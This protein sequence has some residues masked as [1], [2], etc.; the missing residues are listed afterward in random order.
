VPLE[1]VTLQL[2]QVTSVNLDQKTISV[3]SRLDGSIIPGIQMQPATHQQYVPVVGQQ[4]ML[5]RISDFF[6]GVLAYLGSKPFV[7]PVQSGEYLIESVGGA[8]AFFDQSGNVL[9]SDRALSNVVELLSS[10]GVQVTADALSINVK[11]I[12]T[13]KIM[14]DAITVT[15]VTPTGD[16]PTATVTI[17]DQE[18]TVDSATVKLGT[19]PVLGAVVVSLSG[20]PG[21]YS[22]DLMTGRPIPGSAQVKANS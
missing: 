14:D 19:S 3:Q 15:K 10:V 7:R 4:V 17:K 5:F 18:V 8:R 6:T 2:G 9:L 11:G 1:G 20:V 16:V 13:V 12:A 22:F 21:N